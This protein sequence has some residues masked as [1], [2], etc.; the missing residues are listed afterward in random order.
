[1]ANEIKLAIEKLDGTNYQSWKRG[2][3][4]VLIKRGVWDFLGEVP[5]P[6]GEREWR[7]AQ[8]LGLA[9][10]HLACE[11]E[12]KP[13][14][15]KAMYMSDAWEILAHRHEAPSVG[16]VMTLEQEFVSVRMSPDEPVE[17][18]VTKVNAKA[19][20]LRAVSID[21]SPAR[22]SNIILAG[23]PRD[24]LPVVTAMTTR[25]RALR[26]EDVIEAVLNDEMTL[27]RYDS[28]IPK[29]T[30]QLHHSAT[31]TAMSHQMSNSCPP[32]NCQHSQQH[33]GPIRNHQGDNYLR[34]QY[35]N[36]PAR[37]G[38]ANKYCAS[39]YSS[40]NSGEYLRCHYCG[41]LGHTQ[42]V[43]FNKFPHLRPT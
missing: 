22:M 43:C 20:E 38:Y 33:S 11:S 16:N 40:N 2:I 30:H 25:P 14:I 8:Q 41:K 36:L 7:R 10:I 39:P 3:Q 23:L 42:N 19:Q 35:G 13:L 28:T 12:Q 4:M 29:P 18:F 5:E 9:E 26:I 31:V 21:I 15:S 17:K 24:Y 6:G 27:K 34:Q 1:M 32:C 37:Q